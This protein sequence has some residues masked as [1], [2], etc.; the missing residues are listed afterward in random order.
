MRTAYILS[1]DSEQTTA[2]YFARAIGATADW[3]CVYLDGPCE[4]SGLDRDDIFLYVDPAP[5][6]PLG[7]ESVPCIAVAYLIDVHQDAQSRL[8]MAHFFDLVFV[9]QKDYVP[10]FRRQGHAGTFWLP[11]ACDAELHGQSAA[12]RSYEVGFVGKLGLKDTRRWE[13]LT[14][15]LPLFKTNDYLRYHAPREMAAVYGRSK[16]VFNASINGD[17]NMRVFEGMAAG[18]L[19]VTDR[20]ANGLGELFTDGVHYL[21]YDSIDEAKAIICFQLAHDAERERI[22]RAGQQAVLEGHTYLRRWQSIV[23]QSS[24]AGKRAPARKMVKSELG[25]LY[26]EI[27]NSL[28]QPARTGGVCL[29]YGF[30]SRVVRLWLTSWGRWLNARIPLTPNAIRSSLKK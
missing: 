16:I 2:R 11:L 29:R 26:A 23:K 30:S 15:V 4:L 14:S 7:L 28:R 9:A 10:L 3:H 22:A 24:A 12:V 27:F 5:G 18:A 6:W 13:I 19:L 1:V 25:V 21:G 17:L 20:I 8:Q